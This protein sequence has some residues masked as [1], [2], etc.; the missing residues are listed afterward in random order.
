M[1]TANV[2]DIRRAIYDAVEK[3]NELIEK[4]TINPDYNETDEMISE[5]SK[6]SKN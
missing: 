1:L 3:L 6:L 4:K 5:I 2:E